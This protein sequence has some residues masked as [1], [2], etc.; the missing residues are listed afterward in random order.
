MILQITIHN[1]KSYKNTTSIGPLS[2]LSCIIGPNGSGKSNIIDAII[3]A[4]GI[5]T[6]LRSNNLNDLKYNQNAVSFVTLVIKNDFNGNNKENNNEN[7]AN[8][9]E[10]NSNENNLNN[11]ENNFNNKENNFYSKDK[12]FNNKENN[13]YSKDKEFNSDIKTDFM[14]KNDNTNSTF[15]L[16]REITVD[17]RSKYFINNSQVSFVAYQNFLLNRN[18]HIK[19]KN[20]IVFQDDV[21]AISLKSPKQLS[22]FIEHISGSIFLKE[23]YDQALA[24]YN[25]ASHR[26]MNAYELKKENL[27]KIRENERSEEKKAEIQNI[28]RKQ[29]KI[30]TLITLCKI[31]D[32]ATQIANIENEIEAHEIEIENVSKAINAHEMAIKDDELQFALH[33]KEII[34]IQRAVYENNEKMNGLKMMILREEERDRE[35]KINSDKLKNKISEIEMEVKRLES[36]NEGHKSEISSIQ[37]A[38]NEFLDAHI[39]EINDYNL[40][41]DQLEQAEEDFRRNYKDEIL[42]VDKIKRDIF[43]IENTNEF[44]QNKRKE[45]EAEIRK[46]EKKKNTLYALKTQ[47]I[48][49]FVTIK[50]ELEDFKKTNLHKIEQ[51]KILLDAENAK[52][53]E[54]T[55]I[56]AELINI[57]EIRREIDRKMNIKRVVEHLKSIF[58]GVCGRFV[59]LIEPT[60]KKYEIP[61]SVLLGSYD[62]AVV[63]DNEE[64]AI[65]VIDYMK[66]NKYLRLSFL[67]LA[68]LRNFK[69]LTDEEIM[70]R[71][72]NINEFSEVDYSHNGEREGRH[73]SND[74]NNT[75]N[76]NSNNNIQ[77]TLTTKTIIFD[78]KYSNAINMILG[79]TIIVNNSNTAKQILFKKGIKANIATL[80]G[81]YFHKSGSITGGSYKNK[82]DSENSIKLIERRNR[83]FKELRLIQNQKQ[84]F[85]NV[86]ILNEKIEFLTDKVAK[87]GMEIEE[88]DIRKIENEIFGLKNYLAGLEE[89]NAFKDDLSV[90]SEGYERKNEPPLLK[91]KKFNHLENVFFN[92]ILKNT[93]FSDYQKIKEFRKLNIEERQLEMNLLVEKIENK[94]KITESEMEMKN[95]ERAKLIN[96]LHKLGINVKCINSNFDDDVKINTNNDSNKNTEND[97]N[98]KMLTNPNGNPLVIRYKK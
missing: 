19:A 81:I 5:N 46:L 31:R 97:L 71:V 52:N 21:N 69:I 22:E 15:L 70:K 78:T 91:I 9:N 13:F 30:N 59:D 62:Q 12:D 3:F 80:D 67:P 37:R 16:K 54:L 57:K 28:I 65:K 35:N 36:E 32:K 89:N 38:F 84:E 88:I 94:I 86:E 33:Q 20:F 50:R 4:L 93:G 74:Y 76:T 63:V 85:V 82:F 24:D 55:R 98:I 14:N 41:K 48:G 40:I 64:T 53:E 58:T 77:F 25:N 8:N 42:E 92:Q 39:N 61:L 56:T 73:Y 45:I 11:K 6:N 18:I 1:F 66:R 47:K 34:Q 79:N 60:Q 23:E 49:N 51:Y 96:Q 83:I 29:G 75:V 87:A 68:N 44:M 17:G 27:H 43:K 26:C 90:N 72:G 7:E 10:V 2:K 95:D